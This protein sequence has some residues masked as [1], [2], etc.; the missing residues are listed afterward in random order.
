MVAVYQG[1]FFANIS[2]TYNFASSD[3]ED[4][5]W[6]WQKNALGAAWTDANKDMLGQYQQPASVS[7][8]FNANSFNPFTFMWVSQQPNGGPALVD[9]KVTFPGGTQPT[10]IGPYMSLPTGSEFDCAYPA[11]GASSWLD[12]D[13][14]FTG[15]GFRGYVGDDSG[16]NVNA[17][18]GNC[19]DNYTNVAYNLDFYAA[20]DSGNCYPPGATVAQN[21]SA[22][23]AIYQG[24]FYPI[25]D[26]SYT[27]SSAQPQ[28]FLGLW[29]GT[30]ASASNWNSANYL[31]K[32]GAN[33]GPLNGTT[34]LKGGTYTPI[35]IVA[36][37]YKPVYNE[38]GFRIDLRV[39][40][41]GVPNPVNPSPY[42][43]RPQG[44]SGEF[45]CPY[46]VPTH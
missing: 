15:L 37:N 32:T 36:I 43:Y 3:T 17:L 29:I 42:F 38:P 34:T 14:Y 24:Y 11:P 27:F 12:L 35:T 7:F 1:Y 30:N 2:G 21:C 20:D 39:Q 25:V 5:F 40:P 18:V 9:F 13:Q 26:G 4:Y 33:P 23:R 19:A 31:M 16:S 41:P 8:T 28:D 45:D 22:Y 6:V 46:N 10:V 44:T